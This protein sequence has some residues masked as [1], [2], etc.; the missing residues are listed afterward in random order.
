LATIRIVTRAGSL[1]LQFTPSEN[2]WGHHT[3]EQTVL[4][5]ACRQAKTWNGQ[6]GGSTG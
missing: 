6:S 4:L 3:T 1:S 5:E 2:E